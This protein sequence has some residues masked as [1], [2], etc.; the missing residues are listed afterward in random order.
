LDA[1]GNLNGDYGSTYSSWL[2]TT[3]RSWNN[4][5]SIYSAGLHADRV[6]PDEES[7]HKVKARPLALARKRQRQRHALAQGRELA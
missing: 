1:A 4:E 3:C 2:T 6:S 5:H 7:P